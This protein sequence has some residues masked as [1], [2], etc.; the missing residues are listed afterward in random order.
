MFL[1]HTLE[2]AEEAFS[3]EIF[4][5]TPEE[6]AAKLTKEFNIKITGDN[7]NK[8]VNF[9]SE[10]ALYDKILA[11]IEEIDVETAANNNNATQQ[12]LISAPQTTPQSQNS[13]S[14]LPVSAGQT[15]VSIEKPVIETKM[16]LF[17]NLPALDLQPMVENEFKIKTIAHKKYNGLMVTADRELL[18]KIEEYVRK[19]DKD[20]PDSITDDIAVRPKNISKVVKLKYLNPDQALNYLKDH[21]RDATITP[22][23]NGNNLI[24]SA[25]GSILINIEK[26]LEELDAPQQRLKTEVINVFHYPV[27]KLVKVLDVIYKI[28]KLEIDVENRKLIIAASEGE[29]EK[30]KEFVKKYDVEPPTMLVEGTVLKV[31]V[32]KA[33]EVGMQYNFEAHKILN[34]QTEEF[35]G[36]ADDAQDFPTF[37]NSRTTGVKVIGEFA[38]GNALENVFYQFTSKSGKIL[39]VSLK[40]LQ[41]HGAAEEVLKPNITFLSGTKGA[42]QQKTKFSVPAGIDKD[43][44]KIYKESEA[45]LTLNVGGVAVPNGIN[46]D[47]LAD[48]KIMLTELSL[49]DGSQDATG[50]ANSMETIFESQQ[51]VD[52]GE[53]II[54]GGSV[55]RK[56]RNYKSKV[57][58]LGDVPFLKY[59]F[60]S[61]KNSGQTVE[62]LALL[63]ISVIRDNS[64]QY[65]ASQFTTS[66]KLRPMEFGGEINDSINEHPLKTS[67]WN[68]KI[69]YEKGGGYFELIHKK[70]TDEQMEKIDRGFKKEIRNRIK[71]IHEWSDLNLVKNLIFRDTELKAS[72]EKLSEE[73]NCSPYVAMLIARHLGSI[74]DT[75]FVLYLDFMKENGLLKKTDSVDKKKK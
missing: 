45:G 74:N 51:I 14:A 31:S 9:F 38:S 10:K 23:P 20:Y 69:I 75:I 3:I 65:K 52:D 16:I 15:S 62:T 70:F 33:Q 64:Y 43:G 18:K 1:I 36:A 49:T 28:E 6:I 37:Q 19:I 32:S 50:E 41:T 29:I 60:R 21:F 71:L 40:A 7:I 12:N 56:D 47:G 30:I 27:D 58:L 55:Q 73:F 63:R 53:L 68:S 25:P 39:N 26:M 17:Y 24:I 66:K 34:T 11:R 35:E 61:D 54:I 48:Y 4:Y 44:N 5:Y 72:F 67:K 57:P 46:K 22:N 42:F 59:I 2:A 13:N 8:S